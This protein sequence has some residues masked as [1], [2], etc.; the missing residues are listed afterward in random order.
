[1]RFKYYSLLDKPEMPFSG[2]FAILFL[3][4]GRSYQEMA[5]EG[6]HNMT[7]KCGPLFSLLPYIYPSTNTAPY[8]IKENR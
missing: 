4:K 3:N 8:R 5:L 6:I 1:M 7:A 2:A